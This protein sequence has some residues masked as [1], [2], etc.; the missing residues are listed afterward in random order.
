MLSVRV[1]Y[2]RL[3]SAP[4]TVHESPLV[5]GVDEVGRGCLAGP[6]VVCAVLVRE[7]F[8]LQG[9]SDSKRMSSVRRAALYDALPQ[10]VLRYAIVSASSR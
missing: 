1:Y 3:N 4:D 8:S 2:N 6:V 5:I 10:Q 7:D 9:V